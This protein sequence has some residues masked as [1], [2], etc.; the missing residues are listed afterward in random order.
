MRRV[1]IVGARRVAILAA[2]SSTR[3][4]RYGDASEGFSR[5]GDDC[6]GYRFLRASP[7][8]ND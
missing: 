4:E 5:I 1:P 6:G 3:T 8:E 2:G 7:C